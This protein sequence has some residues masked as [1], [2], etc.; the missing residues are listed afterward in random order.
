MALGEPLKVVLPLLLALPMNTTSTAANLLTKYEILVC[1]LLYFD[2]FVLRRRSS[3]NLNPSRRAESRENK[4]EYQGEE[5]S[6]ADPRVGRLQGIQRKYGQDRKH[7]R[8][9]GSDHGDCPV[10]LLLII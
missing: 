10:N 6:E 5:C 2:N 1:L 8:K 4:S 3:E 9:Y 7:R